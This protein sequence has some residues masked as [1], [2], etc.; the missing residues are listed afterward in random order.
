MEIFGL[1]S[2]KDNKTK[3]N[4]ELNSLTNKHKQRPLT[5]A[6]SLSYM[7]ISHV[8]NTMQQSAHNF[9]LSPNYSLT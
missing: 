6:L 1:L 4:N 9:P 2:S 7:Q 8:H 3:N 5:I